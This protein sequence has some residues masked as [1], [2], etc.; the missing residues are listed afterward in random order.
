MIKAILSLLLVL[1]VMGCEPQSVTLY[2]IENV[3]ERSC[4]KNGVG[5]SV[6][7]R[8]QL[9]SK[10]IVWVNEPVKDGDYIL[11]IDDTPSNRFIYNVVE[12]G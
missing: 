5:V 8:V 2:K 3:L 4:M 7:C 10:H 6:R 12:E 11:V 9:E 1:C